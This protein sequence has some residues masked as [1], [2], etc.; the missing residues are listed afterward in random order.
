MDSVFF[1]VGMPWD[2]V[3]LWVGNLDGSAQRRTVSQSEQQALYGPEWSP[4]GCVLASCSLVVVV[5]AAFFLNN[6]VL[7][8]MFVLNG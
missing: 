2:F 6:R 1:P 3:E 7:K 5:F 8:P 4:T